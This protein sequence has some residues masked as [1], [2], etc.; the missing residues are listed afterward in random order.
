MRVSSFTDQFSRNLAAGNPY[1][2][3]PFS[4][5]LLGFVGLAG[6]TC[7]ALVAQAGRIGTITGL[8]LIGSVLGFFVSLVL[9]VIWALLA[10][11][12]LPER[13]ASS[14]SSRHLHVDAGHFL[15]THLCSRR[16]GGGS[17]LL[18][19]IRH[20]FYVRV[21]CPQS[22]EFRKYLNGTVI[23]N[24]ATLESY[25]NGLLD[26][27]VRAD[28]GKHVHEIAARHGR[29]FKV[30]LLTELFTAPAFVRTV[31]AHN[32][33]LSLEFEGVALETYSREDVAKELEP[34]R[35]SL[36]RIADA[37]ANLIA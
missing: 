7:L 28:V 8:L 11:G 26:A 35:Q 16:S 33:Q 24:R 23:H 21:R 31:S 27:V 6:I 19:E 29:D 14:A 9:S 37:A 15:M 36:Q 22:W 18:F 34:Y 5:P 2:R 4:W 1:L 30:T 13:S 3:N 12:V 25:S 20:H 32:G 10:R 17:H